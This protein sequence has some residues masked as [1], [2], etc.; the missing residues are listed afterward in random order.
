MSL[1]KVDFEHKCGHT[2]SIEFD[3]Q[4]GEH[5]FV[6]FISGASKGYDCPECS[7]RI[8]DGN[9]KMLQEM[10]EMIDPGHFELHKKRLN[11]IFAMVKSVFGAPKFGNRMFERTPTTRFV[12]HKE[13]A[14][15]R[16]MRGSW[17]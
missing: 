11:E 16:I 10:V 12:G 2:V 14:S 17:F 5:F 7:R 4:K 13:S 9:V 15:S 3:V 1:Q 6:G 8:A